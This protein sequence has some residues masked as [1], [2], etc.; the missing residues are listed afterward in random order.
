MRA[1]ALKVALLMGGT[2]IPGLIAGVIYLVIALA[3][4]AAALASIIGGIVVAAI[5]VTIG[6]MI[7]AAYGR[8]VLGS[9]R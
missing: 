2:V 3:T 6:L 1:I 7:R 9:H 5:A 8:S 4:G